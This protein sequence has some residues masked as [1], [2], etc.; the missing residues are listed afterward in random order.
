MRTLLL[1]ST[2]LLSASS[3][4]AQETPS[5]ILTPE[6]VFSSPSLNGPVAKGVS[7]SPDGQLVAFLRSREDNVDVQDLWAAPTGEGEPYKLID[8]RALVPDAGE[9]SE[10]EKARRERM[11]ISARGVVEYSWD[12]QGRYIL[13]PL[14][15]DIFLANRADGKVR[16]LTETPADEIDAK[17]SPKGS[18]VS[19]VR[20]QN[21]VVY[22]LASGKETPIT[23]DGAGL[24]T[25]ATAEFIAQEEMDRDTGYWWSPDERYIAMTRVDESPVDIV[26]RFEITGGGATMVEQRYPRAGRPNAVVE[27]YVRDLQGGGRVKVDLGSNTDIYLARVNWSGDGKTLYVQRQSRDQ[28]TLDLLSVDPTTGAS[29]V[30][31]S[32]KAQAWV[33]LNDD[34]RVLSD[35][36]FIWSNED[37]GWRH[38]YLYDRNG[39]RLRAITRGDYPVK[40]LDGVNEQTGDVYFTASMRDGK[41]LPIEQQMFRANLNRTVDPVAVTPG[42][43]WWTVSVNGPA[44]AYVGNYSDPATPTQSALYRIDGTRVRWIEENK[45]DA[46]H[47]FAPYVSR[48]RT[49]EFGTMQS[50]GQTLVWRMT[51]PP[52]FDPSKKYPV[53][54]QVY[55]GPGTGAGVQKSWQPLTNQLLTEAG[56]IVFRVDNRGEGDRSQAF[57]TSIYRRLGIPAVEDQAQAAQWL[58]TLPYVDADHIAV[59]GWSFGGFL[60]LLTLTDKDAGLA[61]ALAGA[62]PTE[63]SLYDTHYTERYMST[64]QANPEGYAATDVLPR[65]DDMTG[66]LLLLHGMADDNV[67]FGNATRVIDALQAKSVPFEM[68]LYPGQRHG[69]RGDPRQL[70]QWRTYLDFL[71]RTIGKRAEPKAD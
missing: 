6:R 57:E 12:Q 59:M 48:L 54:M 55:G 21:L 46:S 67:I 3:A 41:E 30:I 47:P 69:V 33:D 70:Q 68:M 36:R 13:A 11:R 26:P 10:A 53:V 39:R 62:A 44:T 23:D 16:R 32:Q 37:S 64:P 1:A 34:F 20:D 42:G 27:L 24:I 2:I 38:L 7:L 9:L 15:G 40:H 61:S 49:P 52:D 65:L 43:G 28:K 14:E 63:W 25:W 56:Y 8:A 71:D 60:S 17:V 18:Y 19:Y 4:L 58:K 66:R 35:G 31:L 50:H 29:R 45:L 51:T 22:D 5:N